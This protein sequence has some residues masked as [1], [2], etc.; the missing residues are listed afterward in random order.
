MSDDL[1]ELRRDVSDLA[2]MLVE[3]VSLLERR[4]NRTGVWVEHS[5]IPSELREL[6]ALAG[7]L[8]AMHD[9]LGGGR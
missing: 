5:E 1:A 9:R 8:R 3:L 7:R 2:G 4:T 6:N